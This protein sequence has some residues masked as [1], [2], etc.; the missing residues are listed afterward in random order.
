LRATN[1]EAKISDFGLSTILEGPS[2][3]LSI[4]GTPLYSSP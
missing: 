1:F 2:Q 4:C 3:Q